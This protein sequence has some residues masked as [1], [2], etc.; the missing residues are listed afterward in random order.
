MCK[1]SDLIKFLEFSIMTSEHTLIYCKL[2]PELLDDEDNKK[3]YDLLFVGYMRQWA[4]L[5]EKENYSDK[6]AKKIN[7]RFEKDAVERPEVVEE[8][9]VD[10]EWLLDMMRRNHI[11]DVI[12]ESQG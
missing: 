3:I 9:R 1:N 8:Y 6:D 5:N 11:L 4:R 7:S 10:A 2:H 12:K